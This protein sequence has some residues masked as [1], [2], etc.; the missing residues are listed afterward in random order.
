MTPVYDA[1]SDCLVWVDGAD[2]CAVYL[3]GARVKR[4]PVVSLVAVLNSPKN[5]LVGSE[6]DSPWYVGASAVRDALEQAGG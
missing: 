2:V 6:E 1:S 5:V 3:D 4:S